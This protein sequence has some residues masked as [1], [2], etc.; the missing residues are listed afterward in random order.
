[1]MMMKKKKMMMIVMVMVMD[2]DD[3]DHDDDDNCLEPVL[4]QNHEGCFSKQAI[5]GKIPRS[6]NDTGLRTW[7][8]FG[9]LHFKKNQPN[10]WLVKHGVSTE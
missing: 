5:F 2:D 10:E 6:C 7:M 3:D 9:Y 4:Q 8:M 1:M